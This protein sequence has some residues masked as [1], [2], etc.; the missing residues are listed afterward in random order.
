MCS[1]TLKKPISR[2]TEAKNNII[3]VI[4]HIYACP[5]FGIPQQ[6]IRNMAV[7][8][9]PAGPVLAGPI[10]FKVSNDRRI[11]SFTSTVKVIS[12]LNVI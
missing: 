4:V 6:C 11:N 2:N 12:V 5:E 1:N 7:G 10:I 3:I 8:S 9:G